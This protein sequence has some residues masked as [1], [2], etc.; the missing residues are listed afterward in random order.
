MTLVDRQSRRGR[1]LAL[2]IGAIVLA[3][4]LAGG[5]ALTGIEE[6]PD[7]G[8]A[9]PEAGYT[10]ELEGRERAF[11]LSALYLEHPG[12]E[13]QVLEVEALTSPN[14]DYIGGVNVWPRD[15]AFN[16]LSVGPGYPA[17]EIKQHHPLTEVIPST[18][19]DLEPLPGTSDPQPLSLALGF[20]LTSGELGAVNGVRVV[21]KADGK[22]RERIFRYALIVCTKTA[23]CEPA[24]GENESDYNKRV[25]RQFGLL[26]DGN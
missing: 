18:E 25:L 16:A 6:T 26:P 23:L 11:T 8:P 14:V 7:F 10:M 13:L 17:P 22:K 4:A 1:W 24:G 5:L 2:G 12:A 15:H 9:R 19:T 21:Y 3:G 20:R